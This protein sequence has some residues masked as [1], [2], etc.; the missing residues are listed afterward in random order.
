VLGKQET[1]GLEFVDDPNV[2]KYI[3]MIHETIGDQQFDTQFSHISPEL[4]SILKQMLKFNPADRISP[5]ECIKNPV[6]DSF[7]NPDLERQPNITIKLPLDDELTVDYDTCEDL[8]SLNEVIEILDHEIN[9][10][11]QQS[12]S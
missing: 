10:F 5:A 8:K 1:L 4:V 2:L 9:L 7:R 12:K 6:F 11:R 3:K